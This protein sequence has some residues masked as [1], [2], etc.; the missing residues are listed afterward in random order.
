MTFALYGKVPRM[1]RG[2]V[3]DLI[4]HGRDRLSVTMRFSVARPDLRRHADDPS[5]WRCQ[6]S[7]S[8]TSSVGAATRTIASGVREVDEAVERL[9]G[10][11]YDAFTQAV[12]LPQGEFARFLKGAPAQRRQILQDLLRLG[13]YGRMH[14]L[15]GERCR[16]AQQ[17]RR[18]RRAPTRDCMPTR[19]PTRLHHVEVELAGASQ[20]HA[21]LVDDSRLVFVRHVCR[22]RRA[23]HMSQRPWRSPAP[24]SNELRAAD[25]EQQR[26][27]STPLHAARRAREVSA[28]LAQHARDR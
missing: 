12:V 15:A 2:S 19:R 22:W 10:L 5:Q 23:W 25:A 8:S 21:A 24:S 13:V 26:R 4:S 3:K 27:G 7:A 11:D 1:G 16:D 20:R 28:E 14:K 6:V 17:G 18:V 9:V